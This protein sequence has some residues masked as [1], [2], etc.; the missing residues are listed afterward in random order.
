MTTN[1]LTLRLH[2]H[3]DRDISHAQNDDGT[4]CEP[5]IQHLVSEMD[6]MIR[7]CYIEEFDGAYVVADA[8]TEDTIGYIWVTKGA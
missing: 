1:Q 3:P 8:D 2:G 7:D 5:E 4:P 6:A